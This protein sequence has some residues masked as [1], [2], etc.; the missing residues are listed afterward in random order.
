VAVVAIAFA[1]GWYGDA[2]LEP[3]ISDACSS[4]VGLSNGDCEPLVFV[5]FVPVRFPLPNEF[6]V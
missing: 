1:Q 3:L 2:S 6:R 4:H 5:A